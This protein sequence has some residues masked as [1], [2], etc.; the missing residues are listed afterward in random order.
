MTSSPVH[1]PDN[2]TCNLIITA[3]FFFH[4]Q[5]IVLQYFDSHSL[6]LTLVNVRVAIASIEYSHFGLSDNFCFNL[7]IIVIFLIKM[8][9]IQRFA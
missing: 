8:S 4:L 3:F 2:E 1:A 5:A 9:N 6:A 7:V